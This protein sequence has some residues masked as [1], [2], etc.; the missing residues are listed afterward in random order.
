[1]LLGKIAPV[2]LQLAM[3]L[4][5]TLNTH[6]QQPGG[7][8][9]ADD[10]RSVAT[11]FYDMVSCLM[12]RNTL[13]EVMQ[14]TEIGPN[15]VEYWTVEKGSTLDRWD[16]VP[17]SDTDKS[18]KF[19]YQL[20]GKLKI[21]PRGLLLLASYMPACRNCRISEAIDW[22]PFN[23]WD[24]FS[25]C[26]CCKLVDKHDIECFE[27]CIYNRNYRSYVGPIALN[28]IDWSCRNGLRCKIPRAVNSLQAKV[29]ILFLLRNPH[30]T[31]DR[32]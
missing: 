30:P 25:H 8:S 7:F 3:S 9:Y 17:P 15:S 4:A 29:H 6:E 22:C 1:M 24:R 14:C 20:D 23:E 26:L 27:N 2:F 12:Q 18:D 16:M 10:C 19:E 32:A 11:Y 13:R 31:S 28:R 21:T 5:C